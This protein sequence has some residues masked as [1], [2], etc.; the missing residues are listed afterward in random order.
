LISSSNPLLSVEHTEPHG[1]HV[2]LEQC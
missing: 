1:S 2:V